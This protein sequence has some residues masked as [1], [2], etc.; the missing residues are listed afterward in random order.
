MAELSNNRRE[1]TTPLSNINIIN[2]PKGG[3]IAVFKNGKAVKQR[4]FLNVREILNIKVKEIMEDPVA[5]KS[6]EKLSLDERNQYLVDWYLDGYKKIYDLKYGVDQAKPENKAEAATKKVADSKIKDARSNKELGIVE[7]DGVINTIEE[8][9]NGE[10]TVNEINN[11]NNDSINI[12]TSDSESSDLGSESETITT[13]DASLS[14]TTTNTSDSYLS[15]DNSEII[16]EVNTES[17]SID[18]TNSNVQEQRQETNISHSPNS[19]RFVRT[20]RPR[21][22]QPNQRYRAVRPNGFIENSIIVTILVLATIL[23]LIIGSIAAL[24]K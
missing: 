10:I 6:F 11:Y 14:N 5:R 21:T 12:V 4:E 20:L 18:N 1:V 9:P 23:G 13:D 17:Q 7:S 22:L 15:N 19:T 3:T 24:Y 8:K 16:S 2:D